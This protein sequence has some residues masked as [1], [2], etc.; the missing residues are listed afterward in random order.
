MKVCRLTENG[1]KALRRYLS[2]LRSGATSDPPY[3]LLTDPDASE[4]IPG[5]AEVEKRTFETRL[6][7]ARYLDDALSTL[8]LDSIETDIGLW[9]W[10]S[11]FYFDQV[12]PVRQDGY[13]KP[14]GDYRHILEPGYRYGHRHLLA[15]SYLPYSI[16]GLGENDDNVIEGVEF[17]AKMGCVA[18]LR[19]L[20]IDDRNR[21]V[22]EEA[23]GPLE[24]VTPER[25]VKLAHEAENAFIIYDISP[26]KFKTMCHECTC[27]DLVPFKDL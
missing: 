13:R 20:K 3:Q 25:M 18:T 8:G 9:S 21:P 4:S 5:V 12:C 2:S 14:G 22:L 11:L 27:C 23:L 1:I 6:D 7:A 17:L 24:P 15:G 26:L 10:L 19:A 16:Y